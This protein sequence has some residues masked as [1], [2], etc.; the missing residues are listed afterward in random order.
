M[1]LTTTAVLILSLSGCKH[2]QKKTDNFPPL[3]PPK[4]EVKE[5]PKQRV[6]NITLLRVENFTIKAF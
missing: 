2:L 3:E 1:R 5:E 6:L 4:A